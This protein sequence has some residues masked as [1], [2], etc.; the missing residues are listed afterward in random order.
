MY[1]KSRRELVILGEMQKDIPEENL[2]LS[3]QSALELVSKR[4]EHT[5]KV[6]TDAY[7]LFMKCV[8]NSGGMKAR[9]V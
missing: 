3:Q 8:A 5:A 4:N 1:L 9:G 2:S 7:I 6:P